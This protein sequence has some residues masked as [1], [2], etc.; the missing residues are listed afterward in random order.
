MTAMRHEAG[1]TLLELLIALGLT[2]VVAGVVANAV[3]PARA[4]FDRVPADIDT[5]QRG[6]MAIDV[7]SQALRSA[8]RDV[9][10][11]NALGQLPD[12]LPTVIASDPDGAGAF[13]ALT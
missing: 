9:A 13:R 12:L 4:A 3:P 10:A 11:T 8:G 2:L 5:Q 7:L 6:R 1:F